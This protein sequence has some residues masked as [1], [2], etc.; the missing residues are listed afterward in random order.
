M[1]TFSSSRALLPAIWLL[2][3]CL[4]AA[5][6]QGTPPEQ[7]E[8]DPGGT[9]GPATKPADSTL[10]QR[11]QAILADRATRTRREA[12][13]AADSLCETLKVFLETTSDTNLALTRTA[14]IVAHRKY[15]AAETVQVLQGGTMNATLDAWPALGGYVDSAPGYPHSG[16]VNDTTIKID[17]ESLRAQ[18]QLT[19]SSE[20]SIGFHALE[21]LL[22]GDPETGPRSA[23]VFRRPQDTSTL[24]GQATL[25]RREYLRTACSLLQTQLTV[26]TQANR[27]VMN[28]PARKILARAG[29]L[30]GGVLLEQARAGSQ[31]DAGAGEC[32]FSQE[33]LCGLLPAL[34]ELLLLAE[35]EEIRTALRDAG[36][37]IATTLQ[38]A[39][40]ELRQQLEALETA[41]AGH[42]TPA[43]SLANALRTLGQQFA[44]A[45][46]AIQQ[47]S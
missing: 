1:M 32:E 14:W 15:K 30:S 10:D 41:D 38:A 37:A 17:A 26:E 21:Y 36:G 42:P 11:V 18:H 20:V 19:D 44:E 29:K 47:D 22:W 6:E 3:A 8:P 45:A 35:D 34:H 25:R 27:P 46:D 28:L 13:R 40:A 12:S 7:A 5:C 23:S 9:R 16:I 31:E 33:P 39:Q 43:A 2:L 4:L 24:G